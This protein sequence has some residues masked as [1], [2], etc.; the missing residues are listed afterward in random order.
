VTAVTAGESE[1]QKEDIK[2]ANHKTV[3]RI[4]ILYLVG[5]LIITFNVP[6]D[7][8]NLVRFHH[9]VSAK[10]GAH[11]PF[12]IAIAGAEVHGLAHFAN[13]LF[14]FTAWSAG[15]AFLYASSRTL[16]SLAVED[17]V[18][19]RGL[20][21]KLKRVNSFGVPRNAVVACSTVGLLGFMGT[22]NGRKPQDALGV[23]GKIAA[24]SWLI[25]FAG[26][27]FTFIRFKKTHVS[28]LFCFVSGQLNFVFA[29][30]KN[31]ATWSALM[32][33]PNP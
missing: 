2:K 3:T 7:H 9:G 20:G 19:P 26:V 15:T 1:Y 6:Y 12:I 14:V 32:M 10:G 27:C 4:I 5:V 21:G 31:T 33:H 28:A 17:R 25:A 29:D 24:V 8:E 18:W 30:W 11:S 13:A 23:F 16:H 22:G